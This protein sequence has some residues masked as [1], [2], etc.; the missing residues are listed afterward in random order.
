MLPT[1][2]TPFGLSMKKGKGKEKHKNEETEAEDRGAD[3]SPKCIKAY[4]ED[5]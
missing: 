4:A 5:L 3:T 1:R 2:K